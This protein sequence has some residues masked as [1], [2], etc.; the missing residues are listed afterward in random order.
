LSADGL[1]ADCHRLARKEGWRHS[2]YTPKN[3]DR[4][5]YLVRS[6]GF[7]PEIALTT[8]TFNLVVKEPNRI[9]A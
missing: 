3:G 9:S 4:M 1:L 2:A 5:V 6:L 7:K 8:G